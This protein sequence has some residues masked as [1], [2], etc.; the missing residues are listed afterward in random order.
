MKPMRT[1][2][3]ARKA[4]VHPNTV[5]KYEELG[6][7]PKALRAPNGYRQFSQR[8]LD[9]IDLVRCFLRCAWLGEPFKQ[10]AL[11]VVLR[12]AADDFAGAQKSATDMVALVR[13]ER[14]RAERAAELLAEW[15][16]S[17]AAAGE[18]PTDLN[19]REAAAYLNVT[20]HTL[21]N[22]DRNRLVTVPRDPASGYRVYGPPELRRLMVIRALRR[23]R[24]NLMSILNMFRQLEADPGMDP[25]AAIESVPP[26]EEDIYHS[27]YRWLTKVKEHEGYAQ[28]ALERLEAVRQVTALSLAATEIPY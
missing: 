6:Y 28:E 5:R 27:T 12:S 26:G 18:M 19:I 8:H 16:I 2:D 1:S 22:W 9:Q 21:R 13:E 15:A 23:A 3:I 7:L 11:E 24:Y 14:S 17:Q 25:R 20:A 4:G 10:K